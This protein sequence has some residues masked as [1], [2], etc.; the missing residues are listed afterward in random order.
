LPLEFRKITLKEA[1]EEKVVGKLQDNNKFKSWG[2]IDVGV[3]VKTDT[4]GRRGGEATA[5]EL[6]G[7]KVDDL[8]ETLVVRKAIL[9]SVVEET[10]GELEENNHFKSLGKINYEIEVK[11]VVDESCEFGLD[12]G[13]FVKAGVGNE[14][15]KFEVLKNR[16]V[17]NGSALAPAELVGEKVKVLAEK[18]RFVGASGMAILTACLLTM[19]AFFNAT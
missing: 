4:K 17:G 9:K 10:L 3:E 11:T 19:Y 12:D 15:C 6:P 1:L 7:E 13:K 2:R 16:G 8:D 5:N 14:K 18:K